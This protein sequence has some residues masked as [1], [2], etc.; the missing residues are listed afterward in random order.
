MCS[1]V[2]NKG[3]LVVPFGGSTLCI[4]CNE[5]YANTCIHAA[6][7]PWIQ[8]PD[9]HVNCLRYTMN[10]ILHTREYVIC[11]YSTCTCTYVCNTVLCTATFMNIGCGALQKESKVGVAASPFC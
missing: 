1:R 9:I 5:K 3:Q 7:N 6:R 8:G 4:V 2:P 10:Y 11:T